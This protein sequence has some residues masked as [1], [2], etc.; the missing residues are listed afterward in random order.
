VEKVQSRADR[1]R[2]PSVGGMC[3]CLPF[4]RYERSTPRQPLG[5]HC[6]KR[7]GRIDTANCSEATQALV[8]AS[9]ANGRACAHCGSRKT[10]MW[11]NGPV[12]PK[13]LCNACGIRWTQ[14]KLN[15]GD[16]VRDSP[17]YV[18]SIAITTWIECRLH[19][20]PWAC[21]SEGVECALC[22]GQV[23]KG[24]RHHSASGELSSP[25]VAA[26]HTTASA[27]AAANAADPTAAQEDNPA[28]PAV[29]ADSPHPNPIWV[30]SM[31]GGEPQCC[32]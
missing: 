17:S 32:D 19:P 14:G 21:T 12:G 24:P 28:L 6:A 5:W 30:S 9:Q 29:C 4:R 22:V 13:T 11:R 27:A 23:V 7:G 10:P 25:A 20:A 26:P 18:F 3:V 31:P 16:M 15:P 2:S 1:Q 8:V